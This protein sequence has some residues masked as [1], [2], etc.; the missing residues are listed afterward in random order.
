MEIKT[1]INRM[2]IV[3]CKCK[4][5]FTIDESLR[6][7]LGLYLLGLIHAILAHNSIAM[8]QRESTNGCNTFTDVTPSRPMRRSL[9]FQA[10]RSMTRVG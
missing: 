2:H 8:C 10:R 9:I 6:S 5:L 7:S 4:H 3:F 1:K